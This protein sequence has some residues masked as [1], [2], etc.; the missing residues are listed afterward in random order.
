MPRVKRVVTTG[1]LAP[2]PYSVYS[3]K[4]RWFIVGLVSLA[5]LFSPLSANIYFPV[6]PAISRDLGVSVEQ[7]NVSVVVY[8]ILQG[9]APSFFGAI[10]DVLGRRPVYLFTFVIYLGACA[11]LA[12]THEYWL[13]LVLRGV[14][15]AGS[16]SVIAIGSGTI[17]DIA[18]PKDRGMLV[19]VFGLGPMV[20]PCIGP[21]VGGLLANAYGWQSLFWFLFAFGAVV[22]VLLALVLPETLRSLVGNGSIPARGVNRSLVSI[23]QEH[24]RRREVGKA[25]EPDAASLA[26]R[27]PKKGWKDVKPFAPLKMFLEKD[28]FLVLT[29]NA[30]CY[31]LFYCVTTSTGTVFQ[32]TYSLNESELGLCFLANGIGCLLATFVNGPRLTA[33]YKHVAR[34]VEQKRL[35]EGVSIEEQEK[36]R[37]KDQND[38][39]HFPIEHA[40]LRSMPYFFVG[41]ISSTIVYGW[42]VDEGVH[43]SVPLIMQFI[44]GLTVTSVMNSVNTLLV[45]LYPGQSA[46]AIAAN[47]LYRCLLGAA[48]TGFID[49]LLKRLGPGW[50]FTMLSLVTCLF[51][52]LAILEWRKGMRWR[53]E[54]RARLARQAAKVEERMREKVRT[55]EKEHEGERGTSAG[56]AGCPNS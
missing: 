15:A 45:D 35:E 44:V 20:G 12:N 50:A 4:M 17:G 40:R 55:L 30:V 8:M 49:P 9:V 36:E 10:C 51:L 16:S 27:P 46:S 41:L 6:I 1:T 26:A 47:N 43:L 38:L 14:Q 25:A 21:V 22:L 28:V 31:T 7:I 5:G 56:G 33:D 48:G 19:A 53:A 2:P 29:F 23:W 24:R 3:P 37:K 34:R 32:T 39:S 18:P 52:P 13:L 11:G 42:V 54:R